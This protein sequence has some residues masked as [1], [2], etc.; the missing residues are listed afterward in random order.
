MRSP[1][2]IAIRLLGLPAAW[3]GLALVVAPSAGAQPEASPAPPVAAAPAPS[4]PP[5][6]E[7]P[8]DRGTPRSAMEGYLV[9]A[10]AG[11]WERAA[12]YLDL[13]GVP[14]AE[15]ERQGPV[16]AQRLKVVLDRT[17]WV[18]LDALS[19][20]PAG[21]T[22]DGLDARH[23]LVGRIA[24]AT[25]PLPVYLER[26]AREDGVRIWK[27]SRSTLREVPRLW[28]EFGDGALAEWL[29]EPLLTW[30]VL[31]IRLWQWIALA[32]GTRVKTVTRIAAPCVQDFVLVAPRD[33]DS[34]ERSFDAWW[35]SFAPGPERAP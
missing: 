3:I 14:A 23:E 13:R 31:E 9:A 2:S 4:T 1:V 28:D 25:P 26:V 19:D 33:F 12:A 24:A 27:I 11:E 15:R 6:P 32:A 10:R 20:E 18:D 34:A 16:L 8:Y 30:S 7:D 35:E 22:Q 5:A 29:P 21:S 17:L